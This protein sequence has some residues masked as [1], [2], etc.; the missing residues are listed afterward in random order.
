MEIDDIRV[1]WQRAHSEMWSGAC[2]CNLFVSTPKYLSI[3]DTCKQGCELYRISSQ[4]DTT[5]AKLAERGDCLTEFGRIPKVITDMKV[6][7][8]GE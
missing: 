6:W 2:N 3:N 8:K 1:F 5:V 4:G 7:R